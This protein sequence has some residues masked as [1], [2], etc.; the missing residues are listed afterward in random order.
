VDASAH[1]RPQA[2]SLID[3]SA[4]G[5]G[6]PC[7]GSPGLCSTRRGLGR[8]RG[9]SP[10]L[11]VRGPASVGTLAS[12]GPDKG[13]CAA[14]VLPGTCEDGP[15]LGGTGSP[16]PHDMVGAR[17]APAWAARCGLGPWPAWIGLPCARRGR[18]GP[19][20]WRPWRLAP[21]R[22]QLMGS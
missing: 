2:S 9:G 16:P 19:G 17:M 18:R 11:S 6:R 21:G 5:L 1:A 12:R 20:T 4:S 15:D 14:S 10:D 8:P 7:G 3:G 13:P 22:R